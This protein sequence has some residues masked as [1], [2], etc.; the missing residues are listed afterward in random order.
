MIDRYDAGLLGDGG[1]GDVDWWHDYIRSE[2][3]RAHDFYGQQQPAV[4]DE[5]EAAA[6]RSGNSVPVELIEVPRHRYAGLK[7]KVKRLEQQLE[8]QLE[9]PAVTDEPMKILH[10]TES[11][12]DDYGDWVV[13]SAEEKIREGNYTHFLHR[14]ADGSVIIGKLEVCE[15][16]VMIGETV[17]EVDVQQPAVT[18]E[19]I[20]RFHAA[21]P[22]VYRYIPDSVLAIAL[23]AALKQGVSD[24]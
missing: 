6:Y 7:A 9:Q 23:S 11:D 21:L 13:G 24:D 19:A 17:G 14:G 22:E 5:E 10:L 1:S 4:T 15:A 16:G 20:E 18:D 3:D 12:V 2:L 8:Q